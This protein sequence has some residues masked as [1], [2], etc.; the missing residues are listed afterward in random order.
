MSEQQLEQLA[1]EYAHCVRVCLQWK[2]CG[3]WC[4]RS[5]LTPRYCD[6]YGT[7]MPPHNEDANGVYV[8][9]LERASEPPRSGS[10]TTTPMFRAAAC[11]SPASPAWKLPSR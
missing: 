8:A 5:A 9:H 11:C 3:L 2:E 1:A 10:I 4:G 7:G 6:W